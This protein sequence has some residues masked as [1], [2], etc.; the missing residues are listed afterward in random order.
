MK[1]SNLQKIKIQKTISLKKKYLVNTK[2]KNTKALKNTKDNF[3]KL[4][5]KDLLENI[6]NQKKNIHKR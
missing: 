1:K 4:Q 6:K 3:L 2:D 5:M